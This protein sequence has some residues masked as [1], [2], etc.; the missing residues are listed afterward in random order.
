MIKKTLLL[1]LLLASGLPALAQIEKG[2][3]M[4]GGSV[5]GAWSRTQSTNSGV[6]PATTWEATVSPN[7]SYFVHKGLAV[8]AVTSFGASRT[9]ADG[10]HV[11]LN[12]T[13]FENA[14]RSYN[15]TLGPALHYF[16]MLG[17]KLALYAHTSVA[18]GKQSTRYTVPVTGAG[19]D[20]ILTQ[21]NES[22]YRTIAAGPGLAFFLNP[23]VALLGGLS[24]RNESV[25][26][27]READLIVTN[28]TNGLYLNIG[29]QVFLGR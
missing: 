27:K 23:H 20:A 14:T 25:K 21:T 13:K 16:V 9:R 10:L 6:F 18:W 12:G 29:A 8:G 28:T 22:R 2:N 11:L 4:L 5:S 7:V 15:F 19:V 17:E 3:V 24:Y 26:G 1:T